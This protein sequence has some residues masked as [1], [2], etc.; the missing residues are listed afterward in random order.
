MLVKYFEL[1][2]IDGLYISEICIRFT[3]IDFFVNDVNPQTQ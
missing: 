3:S 2:N 1:F